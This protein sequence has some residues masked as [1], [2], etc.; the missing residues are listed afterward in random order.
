MGFITARGDESADITAR[1]DEIGP[2][3]T[4]RGDEARDITTRGDEKVPAQ[5]DFWEKS[6]PVMIADTTRTM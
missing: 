2:D 4:T 1:G 5:G 3:I 6:P